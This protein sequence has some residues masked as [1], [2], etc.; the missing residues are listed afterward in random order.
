MKRF[1]VNDWIPAFAGMTKKSGMGRMANNEGFTLIEIIILV[2][3]AGII[4]PVIVVPFAT[5]IRGSGKPEMVT[6]SMYFAHQ[7][8][9]ELMK[10]NYS[11]GALTP[12]GVVAFATG[13]VNYPG[14]NEIVYVD[15]NFS[16]PSGNV[17]YKR[18]RVRV[19]DPEASTYE[20]YSVVTNFP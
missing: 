20:V 13:D 8:M 2:V 7:R 3:L 9:E 5:G 11:N 17:G 12:A 4:I 16:T 6:R 1:A 19:T 10:Y 15:S 14:E 18:I